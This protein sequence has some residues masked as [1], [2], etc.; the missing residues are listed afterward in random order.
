M[1]TFI[2]QDS[3]ENIRND[4]KFI[5]VHFVINVKYDGRRKAR[6]VVGGYLTNPDTSEIY[7]GVASIQHAS[8]IFILVDLNDLEVIAADLEN[9][10]LH[11]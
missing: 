11:S 9:A 8:F 7:S 4:F 1:N 6:L 3:K 10:Y 5:P 2:I